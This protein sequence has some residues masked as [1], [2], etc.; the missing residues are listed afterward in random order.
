MI[1]EYFIY[2]LELLNTLHGLENPNPPLIALEER[3]DVMTQLEFNKT[4]RKRVLSREDTASLK[5]IVFNKTG[6]MFN[7]DCSI[8]LTDFEHDQELIQLSCNHCF[9]PE[10]IIKWLETEKAECPLCRKEI[11]TKKVIKSSETEDIMNTL[12]PTSPT[13]IYRAIF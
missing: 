9:I 2:Y 4:L 13:D 1:R 8:F 3:R 11:E 7:T 12:R 6:W 5:K 10:G